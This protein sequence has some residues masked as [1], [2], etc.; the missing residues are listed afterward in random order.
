MLPSV[1]INLGLATARVYNVALLQ[2][3]I[4]TGDCN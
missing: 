2:R 3:D 1:L 4:L